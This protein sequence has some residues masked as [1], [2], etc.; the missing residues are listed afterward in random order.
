M[1]CF[2]DYSPCC[3]CV[4]L[5]VQVFANCNSTVDVAPW[6]LEPAEAQL[7]CEE[8]PLPV[9]VRATFHGTVRHEAAFLFYYFISKNA[10]HQLM[11]PWALIH[12]SSSASFSCLRSFF[13]NLYLCL[14]KHKRLVSCFSQGTLSWLKHVPTLTT[15]SPQKMYPNM[16]VFIA[17]FRSGKH[18]LM[19]SLTV[20]KDATVHEFLSIAYL[21]FMHRVFT[22]W[23]ITDRPAGLT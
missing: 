7:E 19:C 4:C 20:W 1:T 12:N 16:S 17:Y 6:R 9:R 3:V 21:S 2:Q 22:C 23:E 14:L 13:N 18:S 11:L 10:G 8:G 5:C 15:T